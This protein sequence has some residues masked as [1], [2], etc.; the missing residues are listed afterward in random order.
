M[1]SRSRRSTVDDLHVWPSRRGI[2][3]IKLIQAKWPE[4]PM[5]IRE[6]ETKFI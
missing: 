2:H 3:E 1:Q 6:N 5:R 4:K